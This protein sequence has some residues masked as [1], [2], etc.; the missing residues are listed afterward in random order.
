MLFVVEKSRQ[1]QVPCVRQIVPRQGQSLSAII[2]EV[3]RT[4]RSNERQVRYAIDDAHVSVHLQ[5]AGIAEKVTVIWP[6]SSNLSR[7]EMVDLAEQTW[8]A[9]SSVPS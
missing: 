4:S 6:A 8:N 3:F 1:I 2:R 9:F 5:G 7:S